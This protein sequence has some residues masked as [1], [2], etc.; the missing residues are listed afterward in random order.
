MNISFV[1][2]LMAIFIGGGILKFA[3]ENYEMLKESGGLLIPL[4]CL[5]GGGGLAFYGLKT[6]AKEF[7]RGKQLD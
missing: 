5:I 7:A 1:K 3:N 4:I 6:L 2:P